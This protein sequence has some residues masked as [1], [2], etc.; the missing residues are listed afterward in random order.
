MA[1]AAPEVQNICRKNIENEFTVRGK[2][3]YQSKSPDSDG[4]E[5]V[6]K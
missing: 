3:P 2:M 5:Y 6:L 1:E 4:I